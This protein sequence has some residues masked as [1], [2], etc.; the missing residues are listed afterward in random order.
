MCVCVCVCVCVRAFVCVCARA[1]V[2]MCVVVC[3]RAR[4]CACVYPFGMVSVT[5]SLRFISTL[6]VI[7]YQMN[8][9]CNKIVN[10]NQCQQRMGHM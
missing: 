1:R 3:V 7:Y 4:A 5:K 8:V 2:C 6:T 9:E 10:I